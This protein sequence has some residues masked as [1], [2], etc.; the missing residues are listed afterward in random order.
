MATGGRPIR[1]N[2]PGNNLPGVR[3]LRTLDDSAAV[4]AVGGSGRKRA[5]KPCLLPRSFV[6][7]TKASAAVPHDTAAVASSAVGY[8][9]AFTATGA[10]GRFAISSLT[11]AMAQMTP[12][13]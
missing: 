1:P 4:L 12:A 7:L 2:L 6:G 5:G 10:T 3:Y 11:S 8:A 9:G 13:V